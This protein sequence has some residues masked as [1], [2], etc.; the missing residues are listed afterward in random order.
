MNWKIIILLALIVVALSI[1]S[2]TG[3]INTNY[4]FL[5][6]IVTAIVSGVIIA[7]TCHR[8]VFMHGVVAGLLGGI[9]GSVIQ[10]VFFDTYI[11]NNPTSLDGFKNLTTS[12]EPTY[13][14]LF[15]G[16]FIG[17]AYGIVVGVV[18]YVLH[19]IFKKNIHSSS[20]HINK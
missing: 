16:P 12:L 1:A 8:M 15:S 3:A 5:Y 13:V 10:A 7:K 2:L 4:I 14:L 11:E 17:I 6:M 9:L 18:A 19:G 20:K